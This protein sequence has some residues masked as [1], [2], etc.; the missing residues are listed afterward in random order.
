MPWI[1]LLAADRV[2]LLVE[3]VSRDHVLDA[4]ARLLGGNSPTVTPAISAALRDREA[5]GSTGIGRGVAIPHARGPMFHQPRGAFL[6]L[7]QP[8]D[9]G[10]NDGQPV[11]LV[12]AMCAPED[13]PELHLQHLAGIAERF[14]EPDFLLTLRDAP[15]LAALRTALFARPSLVPAA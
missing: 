2:V 7:V 9:F 1:D 14:A 12:F 13:L 4:A 15:D 3:P 5:I 11:D 8:V 6:R 10:A